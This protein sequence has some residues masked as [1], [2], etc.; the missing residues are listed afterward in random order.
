MLMVIFGAGASYDS[1]FSYRPQEAEFLR[2]DRPSRL[3]LAKQLFVPDFRWISSRYEKCQFL[4][5]D[6][7]RSENVEEVLE[8][9]KREALNDSERMGQLFALR[10]YIRDVIGHCQEEWLRETHGVLNHQKLLDHARRFSNICLVTFNYDE[11]IEKALGGLGVRFKDVPS[12]IADPK[13]SLLKLHGSVN[14]AAYVRRPKSED[15]SEQDLIDLADQFDDN[16]DYAGMD[17]EPWLPPERRIS[18]GNN[19]HVK[20][21]ALAIPTAAKSRFVCPKEHVARLEKLIPEVTKILAIGWRGTEQHFLK[22]LRDNQLRPDAQWLIVCESFHAAQ[23]TVKNIG[24]V[25]G[26]MD[27]AGGTGFSSFTQGGKIAEFLTP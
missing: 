16:E 6:L 19:S 7:E 14:W 4:F 11:L 25:P 22:L 20:I 23:V 21:P 3:P 24:A 27:I 12:Y 9:F 8:V 15:L 18:Q 26:H 2:R 10:Y 13:W 17:V 1:C 5:P